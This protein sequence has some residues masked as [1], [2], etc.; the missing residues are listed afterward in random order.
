[1]VTVHECM[2]SVV[3]DICVKHA[4]THVSMTMLDMLY[5]TVMYNTVERFV[6]LPRTTTSLSQTGT[7]NN[8]LSH[9][10]RSHACYCGIACM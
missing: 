2:T 1:M 4:L 3:C 5:S 9:L 8:V 6:K 10:I 7:D